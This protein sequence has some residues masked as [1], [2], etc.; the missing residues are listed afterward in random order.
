VHGEMGREGAAAWSVRSVELDDPLLLPG[1]HGRVAARLELR[2]QLEVAAGAR[3]IKGGVAIPAPARRSD[4]APQ[5]AGLGGGA[6]ERH[7]AE[8]GGAHRRGPSALAGHG[9][10][11]ARSRTG[12]LLR[13]PFAEAG[14]TPGSE[15]IY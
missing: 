2:D 11:R 9:E 15:V 13:T 10:G 12:Q 3:A 7:A 5:Q 8:G 14:P 1:L 6:E 4:K